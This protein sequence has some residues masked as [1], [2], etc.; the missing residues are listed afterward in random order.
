[1]DHDK[2]LSELVDAIKA[3]EIEGSFAAKAFVGAGLNVAASIV[4]RKRIELICANI[5]EGEEHG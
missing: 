3:E 5:L 2:L 4:E 1:M